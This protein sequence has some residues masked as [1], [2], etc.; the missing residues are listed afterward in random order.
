[1]A[2]NEYDD[3]LSGGDS[4]D[5]LIANDE[6]QKQ[7]AVTTNLNTALRYDPELFTKAK[8]L[9][10]QTG[11]PTDLVERN[12]PE[13]EKRLT[14]SEIETLLD[15]TQTVKKYM[16][17]QD[18]AK[19]AQ[20]DVKVLSRIEDL[21]SNKPSPLPDIGQGFDAA[22]RQQRKQQDA[23]TDAKWATLRQQNESEQKGVVDYAESFT[24]SALAG[25]G[26]DLPVGIG[27]GLPAAVFEAAGQLLDMTGAVGTI[28]P[29]NPPAMVGEK[30]RELADR[31]QKT[32]DYIAGD[33]SDASLVERGI[34]SGFR[35]LGANT[36]PLI[37]GLI[38]RNPNISLSALSGM[39]G[40]LEYL[41]AREKGLQ[42]SEATVFAA[43]QA[44]IE[45]A[46]EK[47]PVNTLFKNL[48]DGK[49]LV[50]TFFINQVQEQ[51]GEQVATVL[52]DLN[53]WAALNPDKPF[54]AY[55]E[56]RP[57]AAAQTAIATLVAGGGQVAIGK[58]TSV[59][60]AVFNP[61]YASAKKDDA[62]AQQLLDV[63]GAAADSSLRVRDAETFSQL[64]T[65]AAELGDGTPSQVYLNAAVLM[66]TMADAGVNPSQVPSIVDQ[67]DNA[68]ASGADVVVSVGELASAFSG[69]NQEAALL[70]QVRFSEDGATVAEQREFLKNAQAAF[71]DEAERIAAQQADRDDFDAKAQIV[72]DKVMAELTASGR[73]TNDVNAVFADLVKRFF[74]VQSAKLNIT[75][76]QMYDKYR[77]RVQG[78]S[79]TTGQVLEQESPEFRSWFKESKGRG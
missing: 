14:L 79:T 66:Q 71:A 52:Q 48:R 60:L 72:Y 65:E 36:G 24:R 26:V 38:L 7:Q 69:T 33:Q 27:Y 40:G 75:P 32:G 58:A 18:F 42:P 31:A 30:L 54:S 73:H 78:E 15:G 34:N 10:N 62:E 53:T 6:K 1:M 59:A 50:S 46:T 9:S 11:L 39:T 28:L 8:R 13:V 68:L 16:T 49:G 64:V 51:V 57:D 74:V 4:Y 37:A 25:L 43:S 77:L 21:L 47:I 17:D 41:E 2:R 22:S 76:D 45:Y 20:D 67:L 56:E 19:M 61:R 3:M 55:L 63:M 5:G 35:S 44:A 23:M 70:N 12:L 29:A